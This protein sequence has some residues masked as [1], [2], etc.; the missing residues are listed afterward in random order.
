MFITE[1]IGEL[2]AETAGSFTVEYTPSTPHDTQLMIIAPLNAVRVVG[3]EA[4]LFDGTVLAAAVRMQ[5]RKDVVVANVN[6]GYLEVPVRVKVSVRAVVPVCLSQT[7]I[8]VLV[9][10]LRETFIVPL[11]GQA[12]FVPARS[13][14]HIPQRELQPSETIDIDVSLINDGTAVA[15]GARLHFRPPAWT[16]VDAEGARRELNRTDGPMMVLPLPDLP[17]GASSSHRFRATLAPVIQDGTAITFEAFVTHGERRFD[18]SNVTAVVRSHANLHASVQLTEDRAFRY[19]ESVAA[20]IKLRAHGSDVARAVRVTLDSPAIAW[21]DTPD[22]APLSLDFGDVPPLS[23]TA[24][25]VRG[26]IIATPRSK[27]QMAISLS[28]TA[29][30]GSIEAVSCPINVAGAPQVTSTVFVHELPE[31]AAYEVV[32]QINNDGDGE[33]TSV[34]V[35]SQRRE[36]IVGV[37]DSLMID[38]Q[39]RLS[40]DGSISVEHGGVEVGVLPILSARDVRWKIRSSVDHDVALAVGVTVDGSLSTVEAP[41]L[42]YSAGHRAQNIASALVSAK[43]VWTAPAAAVVAPVVEPEPAASESAEPVIPAAIAE[44]EA[45]KESVIFEVSVAAVSRWKAWFGEHGPS[46]DVELGRYILAAREF[47]PV[48]ASGEE[49][50]AMLATLRTE[51]NN[52]V[53]ARLFSWKSTGTIGASGYD[54]ATPALRASAASFWNL[55]GQPQGNLDGTG[56]DLAL[57]ALTAGNGTDF[58]AEIDAFRDRLIEVLTHTQSVEA[59]ADLVPDLQPAAS[60]LFNAICS[61]EVAA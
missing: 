23:D 55:L 8:Q 33:A 35:Q 7:E 39:S 54:F 19:G 14:I 21:N 26:T 61:L 40:L 10:D 58:A 49:Q 4:M 16:N 53:T 37:V 48:S 30:G 18:L 17:V 56:L 15:S 47:L 27:T 43:P 13:V 51:C 60:R 5:Q 2:H 32:C 41:M 42:A 36:N 28:A 3:V 12:K 25:L 29:A 46:T 20:L 57:V 9:D 59:Y 38:G 22:G 34:V 31:E 50:D 1:R 24:H 44:E 52:V 45:V 11:T 6:L